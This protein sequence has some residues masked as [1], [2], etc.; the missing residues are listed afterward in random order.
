MNPTELFQGL[1]THPEIAALIVLI[2]GVVLARLLSSAAGYLLDLV[3]QRT[4]RYTTS[5]SG[6]V[7]PEFVRFCKALVFWIVVLASV[8]GALSLVG[9]DR[10]SGAV[11]TVFGFIPRLVIGIA[12]IASGHLLGLLL[13]NVIAQMSESVDT[14]ALSLRLLHGA[15]LL[16]AIVMGLQQM[17]IDITFITQLSL[18][19]ILVVLGGLGL[20]FA[21]GAR[22]FVSNLIAQPELQRYTIGEKISIGDYQGTIVSIHRTGVELDCQ[23]GIVSIP[24]ALF[25][26]EPVLRVRRVNEDE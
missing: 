11:D 10:M 1:S 2:L 14:D 19:L 26:S 16:I 17:H 18:V 8:A 20:A 22:Q 3:D 12:I 4:A 24:A 15:I 6:V 13:R 23:Q 21:L 5:D 25:A 7:T 9:T